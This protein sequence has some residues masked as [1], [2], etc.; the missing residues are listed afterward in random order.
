LLTEVEDRD[1]KLM[2]FTGI[3]RA[4]SGAGFPGDQL[5]IEVEVKSWAHE[6]RAHGGKSSWRQRSRKRP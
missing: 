6:C 3:E 1:Q 4:V 2:V 5:R